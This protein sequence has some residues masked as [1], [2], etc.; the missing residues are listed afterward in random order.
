[1]RA[2]GQEPA[3]PQSQTV[4]ESPRRWPRR[5]PTVD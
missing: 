4:T 3:P 2:R 1:V 5:P